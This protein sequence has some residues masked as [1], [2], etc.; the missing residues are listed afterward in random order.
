[1]FQELFYEMFEIQFINLCFS[2]F[3]GGGTV[4]LDEN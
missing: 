1:M 2:Y 3:W 4:V